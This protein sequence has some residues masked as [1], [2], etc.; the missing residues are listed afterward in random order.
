MSHSFEKKS[1]ALPSFCSHCRQMLWGLA[2]QGLQCKDCGKV[3]HF[4]CRFRCKPCAQSIPA[5]FLDD[6]A[7]KNQESIERVYFES[8]QRKMQASLHQTRLT[9]LTPDYIH[10]ATESVFQHAKDILMSEKF[11]TMVIHASLNQDKPV[12]AFLKNQPPLHPQTTTVN[13]TRFVSRIGPMFN[14]RDQVML[15]LSWERPLDTWLSLMLY[16]FLCLYPKIILFIPQLFLIYLTLIN[17]SRANKQQIKPAPQKKENPQAA[18]SF[19]DLDGS[20]EYLRNLQNIQ[21]LMKDTANVYD[22]AVTQSSYINWSSEQ[23]TTH[24]LQ[25]LVIALLFTG[26]VALLVSL[27]TLFLFAGIFFYMSQTRFAKHMLKELMPYLIQSGQRRFSEWQAWY[28]QLQTDPALEQQAS[29]FENQVWT[30]DF[31]YIT[32]PVCPWSKLSGF[33]SWATK[34]QVKPPPGCRWSQD[35]WKIDYSGPWIDDELNIEWHKPI[36]K[37]GWAYEDHIP[38]MSRPKTRKRRWIREYERIQ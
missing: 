13:F 7:Q 33:R 36:A 34:S 21:N 26:P 3:S 38:S 1:F 19:P 16:C 24:I 4:R 8:M 31:G 20:P 25:C 18:P 22:W 23:Q 6:D 35:D 28:A 37:Y 9:T 2:N 11:Q 10:H 17:R 27:R 32:D 15:L 30:P 5:R 29:I 14:F 12:T